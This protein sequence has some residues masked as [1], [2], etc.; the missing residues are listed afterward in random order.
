MAKKEE[1]WISLPEAT[2]MTGQTRYKVQKWA[3]EAEDMGLSEKRG[4]HWYLSWTLIKVAKKFKL[5][6]II[7]ICL[8]VL[9]MARCLN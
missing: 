6:M 3:E 9:L 1:K 4:K 7:A 2:R 8:M 5:W